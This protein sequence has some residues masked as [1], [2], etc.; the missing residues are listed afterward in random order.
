MSGDS[1]SSR[2]Y[3][4]GSDTRAVVTKHSSQK[5]SET[6]WVCAMEAVPLEVTGDPSSVFF[7]AASHRASITPTFIFFPLPSSLYVFLF[8]HHH[9]HV[10][11]STFWVSWLL[12]LCSV[13]NPVE[14]ITFL[15]SVFFF[16]IELH[17]HS[18]R[19]NPHSFRLGVL[20]ISIL[21]SDDWWV[22]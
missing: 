11:K 19:D 6:F 8:L 21:I 17:A 15:H 1:L 7:L 4:Q 18:Y 5:H 20:S 14:H 2:K 3:K 13:F 12:K 9:N 16:F 22:T 10:K